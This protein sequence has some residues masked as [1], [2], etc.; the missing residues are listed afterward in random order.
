MNGHPAKNQLK[1]HFLLIFPGACVKC[2]PF[3]RGIFPGRFYSF[4]E[5]L[6]ASE[7]GIING[8]V[9]RCYL[10]SNK[11][12]FICRFE[13]LLSGFDNMVAKL[14]FLPLSWSQPGFQKW[15]FI[16]F[17]NHGSVSVCSEVSAFILAAI[18]RIF[19][20]QCGKISSTDDRIINTI[21]HFCSA[22]ESAFFNL[23][24]SWSLTGINI[25]LVLTLSGSCFDPSTLA[26]IKLPFI[27]EWAIYSSHWLCN[28]SVNFRNTELCFGF[29]GIIKLNRWC[30]ATNSL[31]CCLQ[32]KL[33]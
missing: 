27:N 31:Y 4:A 32:Q 23:A 25:C 19:C 6:V 20:G 30:F 29:I 13:I 18:R 10:F 7:T 15:K 9:A 21:S 33:F 3:F 28:N 11:S 24:G 12:N 1:N 8:Y 14:G 22:V 16:E 17:R 26:I 5:A 2:I